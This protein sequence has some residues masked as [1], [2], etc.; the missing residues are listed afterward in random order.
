[1]FSN[2]SKL[3]SNKWF[4]YYMLCFRAHM[5]THSAF[6]HFRCQR[7]NKSFALKSY[8]NKHYESSCFKDSPASVPNSP[9]SSSVSPAPTTPRTGSPRSLHSPHSPYSPAEHSS[10]ILNQCDNNSNSSA[11]NRSLKHYT[12]VGS[13]CESFSRLAHNR[14]NIEM[15]VQ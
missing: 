4:A 13:Q 8:L 7:C 12:G 1:M 3:K 2:I 14:P 10:L 15:K 6:K 9:N 5:Q 11:S